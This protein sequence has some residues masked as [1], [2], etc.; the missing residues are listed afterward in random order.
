MNCKE[1]ITQ[2]LKD[3]GYDGLCCDG[4]C[5]CEVDDIEPSIGCFQLTLCEPGYKQAPTEED[6]A[7]WGDEIEWVMTTTKPQQTKSEA[8]DG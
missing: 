5:A 8:V 2:Y 3:N 4:E 1:I 7:D 6:K